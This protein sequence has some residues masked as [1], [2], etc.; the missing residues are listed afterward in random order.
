LRS[1]TR[2][3]T[4]LVGE[5]TR[6]SPGLQFRSFG[7]PTV[8]R[9][10]SR[11]RSPRSASSAVDCRRAPEAP[12]CSYGRRPRPRGSAGVERIGCPS[13]PPGHLGGLSRDQDPRVQHHLPFDAEQAASLAPSRA[14]PARLLRVVLLAPVQRPTGLLRG[15]RR[16]PAALLIPAPPTLARSRG[17]SC[18]GSLPSEVRAHLKR[19]RRPVHR[20]EVEARPAAA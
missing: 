6:A 17:L 16:Q 19:R 7:P 3:P 4:R 5:S 20:V 18:P 14:P 11:L 1:V 2:L 12:A 9:A 8:P 13:L 15:K 10:A